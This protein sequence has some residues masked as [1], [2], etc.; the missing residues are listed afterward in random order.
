MNRFLYN[1]LLHLVVAPV[2]AAYYL[3]GILARGKYSRSIAGKLGKLPDDFVPESLPRPRVWFHAVSVGEAA[4]LSP[5]VQ[6]VKELVP[7]ASI[8]VSTGTETGQDRARESIPDAN[9]F[10]YLPLDFPE[11]VNPV[12]QRIRPDLFVLMETELW[13]NL[14]YSLK[15]YGASIALANG[16]ISD[17]SFPRYRRLRK[18]FGPTLEKMDLF[19]MASETDAKRIE[20]MSAPL[21]RIHVTGNTKYDAIPVAT[22][23]QTEAEMRGLLDIGPDTPVIVAGSVHPGEHEIVLDAYSQLTRRF[24]DLT[25]VLVP[26]HVDKTTSIITAMSQRHMGAPFLR[27]SVDRGEK[28]NGR[29]VVVVDR[30]G[31]LFRMYSLASVVFVG[32]SLVPRGGQNV[33]EPAAWGKPV[34]FGPS[35]EDFRD[36]RDILLR[37]AAG[38]EVKS[39]KDIADQASNILS[40]PGDAAAR[41]ARGRDEIRKNVGSA[42]KTAELLAKMIGA[43]R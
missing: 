26:R 37:C 2:L 12:V 39:A 10:L 33:L 28:R 36:A 32:G 19:L 22:D 27:S 29:K 40:N 20:A 16:R 34:L 23:S 18:F 24:P 13:P 14:I 43:S 15:R 5:L 9:G 31:E 17:R 1:L 41:G 3:P 7:T 25:L 35:M 11:F 21:E 4:A 8:V 30:M 38:V 6:A 42:L